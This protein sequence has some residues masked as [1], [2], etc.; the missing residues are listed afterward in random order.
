MW[1]SMQSTSTYVFLFCLE[2][3]Q[4]GFKASLILVII[5]TVVVVDPLTVIQFKEIFSLLG[6]RIYVLGK[7]LERLCWI[8]V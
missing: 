1:V 8:E 3:A 4:M 6:S 2:I 7:I 5:G